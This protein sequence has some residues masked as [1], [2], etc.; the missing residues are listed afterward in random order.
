[1]F[2]F[3]T[4]WGRG[5]ESSHVTIT[6]WCIGPHCTYPPP[7]RLG[8]WY[9]RP[10]SSDEAP[11]PPVLTPSGGHWSGRHAFSLVVMVYLTLV[12]V[13]SSHV[14]LSA[15]NAPKTLL[16]QTSHLLQLNLTFLTE[17]FNHRSNLFMLKSGEIRIDFFDRESGQESQ[18]RQR[19][20]HQFQDKKTTP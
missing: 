9:L 7:P 8:P 17:G 16:D 1:M 15:D 14:F 18:H 3:T 20:W 11:F 12:F 13:Q 10:A 4:V 5:G 2:S 19:V 6:Y